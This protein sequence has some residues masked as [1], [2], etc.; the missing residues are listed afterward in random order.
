M[1]NC[2]DP[3][4]VPGG[5]EADIA[6]VGGDGSVNGQDLAVLLSSWG[7]PGVGDIDGNGIT[8]GGDLAALLGSWGLCN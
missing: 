1:P 4:S 6:P 5:C 3:A 2:P 7:T 8:D